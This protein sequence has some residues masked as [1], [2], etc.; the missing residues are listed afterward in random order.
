MRRGTIYLMNR[1]VS[2]TRSGT[3]FGFDVVRSKNIVMKYS[4]LNILYLIFYVLL[5]H[6]LKFCV[7]STRHISIVAQALGF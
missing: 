1:K 4:F 2:V 3:K 7:S 6:V 5:I